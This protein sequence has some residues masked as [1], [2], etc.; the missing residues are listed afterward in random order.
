MCCMHVEDGTAARRN[1]KHDHTQQDQKS[2]DS[3]LYQ[4]LY[5]QMH[6]VAY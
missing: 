4:V 1:Q 3:I 2:Q 6:M 5:T